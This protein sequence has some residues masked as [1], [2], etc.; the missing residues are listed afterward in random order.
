MNLSGARHCAFAAWLVL[1]AAAPLL[2]QQP[3]SPADLF[4][5]DVHASAG[6]TCASCHGGAA[7][8]TAITR[9]D[10]APLCARCHSDAA[11]I[12]RFNPR[13]RVDQYAQYLTSTHGKRMSAGETRVATC[14]DCHGAHG[15]R[16]I[17]DATASVAPPNVAKTCARCHAD[18]VRMSAF[19]RQAT[20]YAD[21][22]AGVHAAALLQR[23]DTSAPT[24][25]TCHGSHGATPPGID[26][27]VAV[28]SQC[29][30]REAELY[31][32]S[33]K[34][35]IFEILGQKECIACH[36]NHRIAAPDDRWIGLAGP[37]VCAR[38]HDE[39]TG[40]A[41]TIKSVRSTLDRLEQRDSE[42]AALLAGAEQAGMLV[43]DGRT[44]LREA[45]EHLIRARVLVH[46]FAEQ[47]FAS[48]ASEGLVAA[49]RA[50]RVATG[51]MRE[52]RVR[53]TGLL[54][55]V[56]FT[57]GLLVTLWLKIRSLPI[58]PAAGCE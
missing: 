18:P 29:H 3:S 12:R 19:G 57:S 6:L 50:E 21:W 45:H 51:A 30:V 5:G 8:P 41:S 2:A 46:A 24:C 47:P 34:R 17:S 36:N 9:T 55:A 28:C 54:V 20:A 31:R 48:M 4:K 13:L 49:D 44:A 38:C 25:S 56:L 42:A 14:S 11:Y 23:G 7:V 16:L 10:I 32:A 26:S 43:D 53:R 33:P 1:T 52:L 15:I 22:S 40:G 35:A 37:A 27:V 58:P 39:T